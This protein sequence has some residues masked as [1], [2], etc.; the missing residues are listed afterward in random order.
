MVLPRSECAESQA[1]PQPENQR[2]EGAPRALGSAGQ[3][4][5][6]ATA[7]QA[8]GKQAPLLEGAHG[9]SDPSSDLIRAWGRP[10]CWSRGV[11]GG[12]G[13]GWGQR[14][15][16]QIHWRVFTFT[17]SCWRLTSCSGG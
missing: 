16:W 10:G 8:W 3:R 17:D 15:G 13:G 5:L 1:G 7:P 6:N 9:D 4:G 12:A 2:Q 14:S 11:S